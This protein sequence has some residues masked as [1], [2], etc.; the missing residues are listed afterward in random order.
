[1][2]RIFLYL[3]FA[4]LSSTAVV[5]QTNKKLVVMVTRANWC[6]ACRANEGKINNELVPA[7]STCQ[8]RGS[9]D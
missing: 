7:Y 4:F 9:C 8:R 2:Q 1:M 6:P 3:T 5:A